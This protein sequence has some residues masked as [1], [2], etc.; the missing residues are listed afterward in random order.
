MFYNPLSLQCLIIFDPTNKDY[1]L[2]ENYKPDKEI[3]CPYQITNDDWIHAYNS[4]RGQIILLHEAFYSIQIRSN[5]LMKWEIKEIKKITYQHFL[6]IHTYHSNKDNLYVSEL[7][8]H[9]R[10]PKKFTAD[11]IELVHKIEIIEDIISKLKEGDNIEEIGLIS[12]WI[13]YEELVFKHLQE[14]EEIGIPLMRACFTPK[15]MVPVIQK[16]IPNGPPV[17]MGSFIYFMGVTKFRNN[18]MKQQGLPFLAWFISFKSKYDYFV[19]EFIDPVNSLKTGK[20]PREKI[21]CFKFF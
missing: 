17:E 14:E 4:L 13:E 21:G 9:M 19:K 7:M 11:H 2:S 16:F 8:K 1:Q 18:F 6:H 15:D 3:T 20:Q 5:Y 12:K 10:F